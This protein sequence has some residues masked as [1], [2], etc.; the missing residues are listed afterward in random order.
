MMLLKYI[1]IRSYE[2]GLIGLAFDPGYS[3]TLHFWVTYTETVDTQRFTVVSRFTASAADPSV[4]DPTSE[5][6][7][8]RIAHPFENH[9]GGML[10]FGPDGYLYV[11]RGDGGGGGDNFPP[12]GNGQNREVLLGKVMRLDVRGVDPDALPPDCGGPAAVYAIPASNPFVDGPGGNCDELWAYGLRNPWRGSFD[13]LTG[14]LYIGDVGQSCWEEIDFQPASST[15]GQ[16][17]GWRKMEANHCHSMFQV[18][19]CDPSGDICAGSPPCQDPSITRPVLEYGREFGCAVTGGYV[20]RGCRMTNWQGTYFYGDLCPG[21]VKSFRMAGGVATQHLDVTD[22]VAPGGSLVF[23][24]SSF[25]QD[26]QGEIYIT[27]LAGSVLKIVPPFVDLEVSAPDAGS[28]F[29]L[30]KTGP[31][32]WE[33]LTASTDVPVAYYRVYRGTPNGSYIC[34]IKSTQPATASGGDL[35]DPSPGQLF[36]YVVVAVDEQETLRGATGTFNPTTCP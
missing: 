24:L 20:Y 18:V 19:S 5:L 36:A 30:S 22:Q 6:R 16:N 35:T 10:A 1:K 7:I 4:A 31:W 17:Y 25:G 12:C 2:M 26:A 29:L 3:S 33:N 27:S 11:F 28:R 15:G 21:S 23:A 32:T 9:F 34:V 14:D 8:L 13:Q